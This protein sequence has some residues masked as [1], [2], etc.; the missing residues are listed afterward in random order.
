MFK[1]N[2]MYYA[3][4]NEKN[5]VKA[6]SSLSTEVIETFMIR[7]ESYDTALLGMTWDGSTFI[8]SPPVE[9]WV[10]PNYEFRA[11][12]TYDQRVAIYTLARTDVDVQVLVADMDNFPQINLQGPETTKGVADL[13]TAGILTQAEADVILT[14]KIVQ[15]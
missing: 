3:E 14:P 5:I 9:V 2:N 8:P 7:I 13:V 6:V 10:I 1:G 4:L 12:F 11:R 15:G